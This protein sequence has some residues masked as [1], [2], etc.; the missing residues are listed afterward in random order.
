MWTALGAC[1]ACIASKT[2]C[3]V[4]CCPSFG[5]GIRNPD[6]VKT[7]PSWCCPVWSVL[8][9]AFDV[10]H[11]LADPY[12]AGASEGCSL[13]NVTLVNLFGRWAEW[14]VARRIG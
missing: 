7:L 3:A 6:T 12:S 10:L 13:L 11:A 1:I 14:V 8:C 9:V 5:Q 2:G 4:R